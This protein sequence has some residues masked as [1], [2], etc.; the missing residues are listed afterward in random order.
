MALVIFSLRSVD[1]LAIVTYSAIAARALPLRRMTSQ[2]K[3]AALQVIDRVFFLGESDPLEG[4]SKGVKILRDRTHRNPNSCILHLSDSPARSYLETNFAVHQFYVGFG[5]GS[6]TGFV[7]HEFEEFLSRILGGIV[8]E[9]QIRIAEEGRIVR[10]GEMRGGEE[11]IIPLNLSME[12]DSSGLVSI[13]YSYVEGAEENSRSGEVFLP[14]QDKIFEAPVMGFGFPG[15]SSDVDRW[16]CLDP[17]M[18]RR[19]AKH[20][21]G[22]RA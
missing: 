14:L 21:H 7:M 11:R 9:I 10:L 16:D 19:W 17:F 4:L 20:L 5:F 18:A 6:S 15:R 22:Y 12:N 13:A 8:S 1:R 3:R 2:G